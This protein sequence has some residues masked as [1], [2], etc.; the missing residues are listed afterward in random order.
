MELH[1]VGVGESGTSTTN[2]VAR[3]I[4]LLVAGA[5]G[6]VISGE[7]WVALQQSFDAGTVV[8]P[9]EA[10]AEAPTPSG[11]AAALRTADPS[12]DLCPATPR[13]RKPIP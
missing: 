9:Q 11:P 8:S 4:H 3:G 12:L 6:F 7:A 10:L 13:S 5:L 1:Q 2:G